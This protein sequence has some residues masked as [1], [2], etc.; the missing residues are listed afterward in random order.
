MNIVLKMNALSLS[1]K[2]MTISVPLIKF[3]LA[4]QNAD[5]PD[6]GIL[7]IAAMSLRVY[8]YLKIF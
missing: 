5:N 6:F 1:R 7:L 4:S 8:K 2:K 3:E